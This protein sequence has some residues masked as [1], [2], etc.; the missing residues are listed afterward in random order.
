MEKETDSSGGS[1]RRRLSLSSTWVLRLVAAALAVGA[2]VMGL[3]IVP[4]QVPLGENP[5]FIDVIFASRAVVA[6]VRIVIVMAAAYAIISVIVLIW[7]GRWITS[8]FG[9]QTSKVERSVADLS[10]DRDRLANELRDAQSVI[11]LLERRLTDSAQDLQRK[12]GGA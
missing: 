10:S 6:S 2:I 5:D 7:N 8:V 9:V 4:H 12:S 1:K 11:A 3:K